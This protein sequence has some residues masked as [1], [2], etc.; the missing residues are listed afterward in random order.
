MNEKKYFYPRGLRNFLF[1]C[2]KMHLKFFSVTKN[3]LHFSILYE[4]QKI[5]CHYY[6][7]HYKSEL[8]L[9][10]YNLIKKF[11]YQC[12]QNMIESDYLIVFSSNNSF[13]ALVIFTII[14]TV[15]R[16]EYLIVHI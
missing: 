6:N 4:P 1:L 11:T 14:S 5:F 7:T 3:L 8:F 16:C 12:N 9:A 2:R 10:F 13:L 15:G